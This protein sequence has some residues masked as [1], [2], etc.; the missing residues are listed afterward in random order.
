MPSLSINNDHGKTFT[1]SLATM[2]TVGTPT[3][4]TFSS[5]G[6]YSITPALVVSLSDTTL[7]FVNHVWPAFRHNLERISV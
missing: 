4:G 7:L 6:V 3:V 1:G 5:N 2:S